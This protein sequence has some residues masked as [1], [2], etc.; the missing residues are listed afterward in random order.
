MIF[1]NKRKD[2]KNK[3]LKRKKAFRKVIQ[4]VL[5]ICE[6]QET[7]PTYFKELVEHYRLNSADVVITGD[8]GSSPDQVVD[9]AKELYKES[10]NKGDPYDKVFCVIDK[11]RHAQYKP[12]CNIFGK[13]KPTGVFELINSVPC[14]ELWFLFHFEY[15][16]ASFLTHSDLLPELKKFLPNYSKKTASLF[17]Q[18]LDKL[19]VAKENSARALQEALKTNTDNPSTKVHELVEFL[20]SIQK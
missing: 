20:Q 2:R 18:L 6:G 11:D 9:K 10:K 13:L 19:D 17:S 4:K 16:T 3:D 7:E 1:F 5:I 14:F 12:I 15:T 8:C